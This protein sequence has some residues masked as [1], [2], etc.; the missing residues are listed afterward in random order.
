MPG[1]GNGKP[2]APPF[3]P[4]NDPVAAGKR[5]GFVRHKMAEWRKANPDAPLTDAERKRMIKSIL[6]DGT[7]DALSALHGVIL[8]P[9]HKDHINAA[10]TWL[11]HDMGKPAQSVSLTGEDGGA[12]NLI[13]RIELVPVE[14]IVKDEA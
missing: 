3:G 13:H 14:S 6:R 4:L 2:K 10:K 5:G 9:E 8:D 12:V 11:E 7:P 1:N